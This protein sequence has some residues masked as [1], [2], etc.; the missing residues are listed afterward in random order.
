MKLRKLTPDA[1][2]GF[3]GQ[4][5]ILIQTKPSEELQNILMSGDV[6]IDISPHREKRSLNANAYAWVLIDK[7]SEALSK[8]QS[9]VYR[10]A[11][12]DIGGVS[13]Y[14]CVRSEAVRTMARIWQSKGLGWQVEELDSKLKGCT[15]LKLTYGSSVYDTK[16]MSSLIDHLVQDCKA[17]GIDTRTPEQIAEMLREWD[18][19]EHNSDR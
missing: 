19:A 2:L 12:K 5:R 16:Q 3:D 11:V 4:L 15:N 17:V 1:S 14:V 6:D 8:P 9:E 18:E 10:E 13:E 7:L